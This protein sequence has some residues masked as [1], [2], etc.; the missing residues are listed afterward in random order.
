MVDAAPIDGAVH[1]DD[2]DDDLFDLPEV[3]IKS[4]GKKSNSTKPEKKPKKSKKKESSEDAE[5]LLSFVKSEKT[6]RAPGVGSEKVVSYHDDDDEDM[7][8]A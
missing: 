2:V 4:R 1:N 3:K 5:D 6:N 7:L 8:D